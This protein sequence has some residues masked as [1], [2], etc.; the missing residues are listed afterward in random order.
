MILV[1]IFLFTDG[2]YGKN[3]IIFGADMS[4]SVHVDNKE[5]NI[6]IL[7]KGPT[8]ELDSATFTAE[9]KYPINFAQSRKRFAL[10]LQY[11]GSN[12]LLF[13]NATEVYQFKAKDSEIKDYSLCLGNASNDFTIN[14]M[15]KT[16]KEFFHYCPFAVKLDRYVR[17]C[18][19]LNDLSNKVCVPNKTEDLNLSVCNMITGINEWKT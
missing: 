18:N 6:L 14:N 1:Q 10:S 9:A 17:S 2:S 13:V 11:N 12:S 5:K 7:S 4:S 3:V 15:K 8:Q 16:E 19:T